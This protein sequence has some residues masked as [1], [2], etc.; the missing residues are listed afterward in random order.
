[1]RPP[2]GILNGR[3]AHPARAVSNIELGGH[4][5]CDAGICPTQR[6]INQVTARAQQDNPDLPVIARF[7]SG[8]NAAHVEGAS[9]QPFWLPGFN[10]S[11][12][13]PQAGQPCGADVGCEYGAGVRLRRELPLVEALAGAGHVEL[14][15]LRAAEHRAGN[16][17]DG[18]R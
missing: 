3:R 1:M 18:E 9:R 6:Q 14:A 16:V 4:T 15:K 11:A 2:F 7:G 10:P 17:R 12:I 8:I 13:E 5:Q